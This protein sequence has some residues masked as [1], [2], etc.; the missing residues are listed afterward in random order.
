MCNA[1]AIELY[2]GLKPEEIQQNYADGH[3]CSDEMDVMNGKPTG[4][5]R[6]SFGAMSTVDDV[7]VLLAFL[8]EFLDRDRGEKEEMTLN[9][10][11]RSSF[12]LNRKGDVMDE[13][14]M[15]MC[16][17]PRSRKTPPSQGCIIS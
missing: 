6:V 3:V 11:E 5:V 8:R 1:G 10:Q 17:G 16:C 13:L 4:A 2:V 9:G 12:P 7:L 15:A 14:A